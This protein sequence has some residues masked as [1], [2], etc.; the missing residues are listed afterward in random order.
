MAYT[1]E[2]PYVKEVAEKMVIAM[3]FHHTNIMPAVMLV[4]TAMIDW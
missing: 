3:D 4:N 1:V 2:S